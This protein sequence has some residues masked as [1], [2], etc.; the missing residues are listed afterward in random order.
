MPTGTENVAYSETLTATGGDGSYTWAMFNSTTLP[1]GLALNTATG[2]ISGTPTVADTT[3]FEVEV[4]S[5]GATATKALSIT[6]GVVSLDLCK[7][8]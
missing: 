3:N 1:A 5:A 2:E 6:I 4:T 8:G 7:S